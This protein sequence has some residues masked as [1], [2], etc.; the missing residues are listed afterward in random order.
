MATIL[1]RGT[2]MDQSKPEDIIGK[3][4]KGNHKTIGVVLNVIKDKFGRDLFIGVNLESD[5]KWQSTRPKVLFNSLDEYQLSLK[6]T[7]TV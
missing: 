7:P 4:C 6:E 2:T 3:V 1:H 5:K